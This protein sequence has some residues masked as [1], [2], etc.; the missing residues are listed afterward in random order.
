MWEKTTIQ[1]KQKRINNNNRKNKQTNKNKLLDVITFQ[2]VLYYAFGEI[3]I[4]F[5]MKAK[6]ISFVKFTLKIM[7]GRKPLLYKKKKR[8]TWVV[9]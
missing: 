1:N 3:N 8:Q 7:F 5:G 4:Y 9:C 2:M 6:Q